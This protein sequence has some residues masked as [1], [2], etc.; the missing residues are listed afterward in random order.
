[1]A[2][3]DCLNTLV[4]LSTTPCTCF[5][6]G[7]KPA[8]YNTS[9]SGY[10]LTDPVDGIPMKFV[11]AASDC[12]SGGPWTMLA[13]ARTA[14]V[15][16]FIT[17]LNAAIGT[18]H[19]PKRRTFKGFA[20][21]ANESSTF[22]NSKDFVG[23]RVQ[24]YS[25]KGGIMQF[26]SVSLNIDTTDSVTVYLYKSTDLTT[27]VTSAVVSAVA[28]TWVNVDFS[29]QEIVDLSDPFCENTFW[30]IVYEL[31]AGAKPANNTMHCGCG[32]VNARLPKWPYLE[33]MEVLGVQSDSYALLGSATTDGKYAMGLRVEMVNTC[34]YDNWLCNLN[35]THFNADDLQWQVAKTIQWAGIM[36]LGTQVIHSANINRYTLSSRESVYGK[37]SQAEKEYQNAINYIAKNLPLDRLDCFECKDGK[38]FKGSLIATG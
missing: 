31:P 16:N 21:D 4:G 10:Y 35:F 7:N 14:A 3:T 34:S 1:M 17:D 23:I 32:S 28:N 11:D 19:K 15:T 8:S 24:P 9:D 25:F 18:F 5:D 22:A 12:E 2:L 6:D 33:F 13:N 37:R 27:A 38:I 20:G 26:L 30:Y 29:T 36:Y